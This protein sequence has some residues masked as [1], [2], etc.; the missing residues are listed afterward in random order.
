[1]KK[2]FLATLFGM[3]LGCGMAASATV[4]V[5]PSTFDSLP[6]RVHRANQ[7]RTG[8]WTT[9]G[10]KTK[11]T[12]AWEFKTGGPVRSSPV[13]VDGVVYVGSYDGNFYAL[14]AASG[15]Q[16]WSFKT[17]GKVSGSAAVVSGGVFFAGEDGYVYR[18]NVT[19]GTLA[20]N[21]KPPQGLPMAG[22]PAVLY[23][24]V[25]IGGGAMGASERLGMTAA[26]LYGLDIHTGKIIWQSQGSGPQGYAAI[27]TDGHK[28]FAG[29]GGS[30]YGSFD[31][32]TQKN[33]GNF[34]GG[35]QARQ[36]MSMTMDGDRLYIPVTMRGAVLCLNKDAKD[37]YQG[38]K[39]YTA[40]LDGQLDIELNQG[41]A[42]GYEIFTDL[43]VT[44]T[45]VFCG[46]NDGKLYTFDKATG[47]KGW[48]FETGGKVQSSPSVANGEVYFGSWDGHLYA[49]DA[50]T[51]K[52]LWKQPLGGRI[53][54]SPWP[55]DGMIYV[56]CDNGSIY[57]LR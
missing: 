19:D 47:K 15:K 11:P 32:A 17:G 40:M 5:D 23:D 34:S 39:W 51:G 44:D 46:C 38:K 27:A 4:N 41:G 30:T 3:A 12:V 6:G 10:L 35:H 28:I 54:S 14:E 13:V 56:G 45:T 53:I 7:G 18:L 43:A 31:I 8:V 42:F 52:L 29:M 25:F 26:P 49:L 9:S 37:Y 50:A 22:S 55:G 33:T 16:K 36:F 1:M 20:W 21:T 24:T 57:A 48:T 2:H